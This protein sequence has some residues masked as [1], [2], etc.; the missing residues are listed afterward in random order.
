MNIQF[1]YKSVSEKDKTFLES[2]IDKKTDRIETLVSNDQLENS[3]M[4]I[5]VEKF[6]K[7]EAYNLEIFFSWPGQDF[8][9]SE[10]DHTVIEAFDLAFDKL[11][12]QIR[13]HR[14]EL[15]NNK[16]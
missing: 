13:R 12:N 15:K 5:R 2:Y 7:K 8:M 16:K 10:D 14:D 6:A 11:I 3:K 1:S 4:E 9:A